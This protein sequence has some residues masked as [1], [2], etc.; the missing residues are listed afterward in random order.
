MTPQPWWRWLFLSLAIVIVDLASKD[1]IENHLKLGD[2]IYL[3]SWFNIV[4]AHNPGAAFSF[5]ANAGGWQ[6]IFF[7]VVTTV[8]S[9]GLVIFLRKH[10]TNKLFATSM[11]L[12]LGGAIGN[13]YDRVTL[14]YVV[15]FVQ[16]HYGGWAWPAFN[17]ADSSICMGV[18]LMLIDSFRK[19]PEPNGTGASARP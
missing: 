14:G 13:L 6:R 2:S 5:L 10:H 8:V 12:V 7:V 15:D 4:R 17:V 1:W 16:W 19:Q 18:V 3:T 9:I 11:A